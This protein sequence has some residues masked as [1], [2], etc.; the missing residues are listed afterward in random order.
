MAYLARALKPARAAPDLADRAGSPADLHMSWT[1][2]LYAVLKAN[3]AASCFVC[4]LTNV[5]FSATAHQLSANIDVCTGLF[6]RR[7]LVGVERAVD[8][9]AVIEIDIE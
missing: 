8:V 6:M 2:A 4:Q 7:D 1:L 9:G 3:R 5:L